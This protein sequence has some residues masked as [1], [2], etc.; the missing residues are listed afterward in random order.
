MALGADRKTILAMVTMETFRIVA[1]GLA[2]GFGLS[3]FL[4]R[5]IRSLLFAVSSSDPAVLISVPVL[6]AMV[7]LLAS[8]LP[9]YRALSVQPWQ[10]LR[11]E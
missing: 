5:S 4:T 10:T 3:L 9:A 2:I 8:L 7:A 6:I 11:N 1:I